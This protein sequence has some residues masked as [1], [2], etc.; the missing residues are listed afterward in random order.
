MD[1][2]PNFEQGG[3]LTAAALNMLANRVRVLQGRQT[4]AA[5]AA[6][7]RP[8]RCVPGRQFAFRLA[9]WNGLVWVRQG[10]VDAGNG[11]LRC[12]GED[13]WNVVG[14]LESM[15]VWLEMDSEGGR[16][17]S[18][19]YDDSTPERNLRR[20]LGYVRQVA[21]EGEVVW[22]CVQLLGGLV[23]PCAP[24]RTMGYNARTDEIDKG[25]LSAD[26]TRAGNLRGSVFEQEE[27]Q[28]YAGRSVGL[29]YNTSLL[30]VQLAA[31]DGGNRLV[32]TMSFTG[33]E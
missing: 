5:V 23:V 31:E 7:D 1:T 15:T 24:R 9:E 19:K 32:Q 28:Y 26:W 10:W 2:L 8:G 12:V 29:G 4:G 27:G 30:P 22:R 6:V 16:V 17:V 25:E 18:T 13:E 11:R 21:A 20:R 3:Q 33:L 14:E